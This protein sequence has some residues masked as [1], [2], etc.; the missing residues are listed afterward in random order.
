MVERGCVKLM[1]KLLHAGSLPL[2]RECLC[3]LHYHTLDGSSTNIL[4]EEGVYD[5]ATRLEAFRC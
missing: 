2:Q 5:A 4:L 1:V 3:T